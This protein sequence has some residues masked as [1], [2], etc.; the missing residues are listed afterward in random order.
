MRA[1][2]LNRRRF[3]QLTGW[4]LGAAALSPA[5]LSACGGGAS[6]ST[7]GLLI[8]TPDTPIRLPLNRDPIA[9][10]LAPESGTFRVYNYADYV[11][12][13]VVEA[14]ESQY[15]VSLEISTYTTE[16]EAIT[17]L[18]S[19]AIEADL[20]IGMTDASMALLMAAELV[21]PL[22]RSYLSNFANIISGLQDP[23]Y[24]LGSQYTVPHVIYADGIGYRT[25]LD[26][27]TSVLAGRE[28]WSALWDSRYRGRVG[29]LDSYRDSLCMSMFR[30]GLT[31]VN[32]S[33]RAVV[34][35]AGS[36]L[37]DLVQAVNPQIDILSY[38]E[39][40]A[41]NRD[42]ALC[43]SGD[44]LAGP[45]YLPEG[46]D[47]SVLGFWYPPETLTANDF[48][49]VLTRATKPVLAHCFINFLLD[50]DNALLNQTYVGYQP[51]LEAVTSDLL[52]ERN[53]IP[54]SLL[55]ALV[56]PDRYRSGRR[57]VNLAPEVDEMWIDVW[58][59]FTAG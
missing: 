57:L 21:Q 3:I 11:N 58:S 20:M 28:G 16:E 27:D 37:A 43:W 48:F 26:V 32:T 39:I 35:A 42:I 44:M 23:Y 46:T 59:E 4:G 47:P 18:R 52:I 53:G 54:E 50:V 6:E 13:D 7:G 30:N 40:P 51:A 9:D 38:Q 33:D 55:S 17:K 12:P 19:G 29:I 36:D 2:H 5:L 25:D 15:G 24:D 8:G 45:G 10:G 31:D 22:N 34:E 56:T 14:F 1:H 49:C 41:G